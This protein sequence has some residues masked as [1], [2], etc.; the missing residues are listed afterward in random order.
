M[1]THEENELMCRVGPGTAMGEF[2]REYWIPAF[3]PGE[4]PDPDG[5]PLRL[6]L[7]GENLIAFHTTSGKYGM[8]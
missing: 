3:L 6:R 8:M 7:L 4:L 1:L 2:L 5:A